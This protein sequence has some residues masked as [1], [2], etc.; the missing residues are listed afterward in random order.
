MV[1]CV[2]AQTCELYSVGKVVEGVIGR[3]EEVLGGGRTL[4]RL[5][6]SGLVKLKQG[7]RWE[8][9]KRFNR[10]GKRTKLVSKGDRRL[11]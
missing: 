6:W 11:I 2:F 8:R 7:E 3:G 4:A 9:G 5:L 10:P 1:N